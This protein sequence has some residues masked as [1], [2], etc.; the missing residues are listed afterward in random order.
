MISCLSPACRTG[1]KKIAPRPRPRLFRPLCGTP[2]FRPM[3]GKIP[4]VLS[5]IRRH[6]RAAVQVF[7]LKGKYQ[8]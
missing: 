4:A 6:P 3:K 8:K 2:W 7:P 1:S 5:Q